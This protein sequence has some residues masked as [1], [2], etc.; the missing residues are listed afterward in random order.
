MSPV[1]TNLDSAEGCTQP[2]TQLILSKV[3]SLGRWGRCSHH[4]RELLI[5][6][7]HKINT[8][9]RTIIQVSST[10]LLQNVAASIHVS[11]AFK[12]GVC[13]AA[14]SCSAVFSASPSSPV[15]ESTCVVGAARRRRT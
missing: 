14:N 7:P 1:E 9:M 15:I 10:T 13:L 5:I 6:L 2:G 4:P 3:L 11:F 8:A 12:V